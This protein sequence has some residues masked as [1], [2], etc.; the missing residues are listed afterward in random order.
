MGPEPIFVCTANTFEFLLFFMPPLW[1]R[2]GDYMNE[3]KILEAAVASVRKYT[4]EVPKIA[5]ILGSGL[6]DFADSIENAVSIDYADIEGFFTPKVPGHAG[7]LIIGDVCGIKV[8]ALAGRFHYYE[9]HDIAA[10]VRPVRV[11]R[12]LG[13]ERLILTNAAGGINTDYRVGDFM[14]ISDH[15][16]ALIPSP[17]RGENLEELG[18]RFPDMTSVYSQ[19]LRAAAKKCALDNGITVHEGVY[20]QAP[21]PQFET[22]AEIKMYRSWGA[23]AVGMSTACEAI[24][25]RH[26]GYEICGISMISNA[27]AGMSGQ[28]LTHEEVKA[29]A[30]LASKNFAALVRSVVLA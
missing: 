20:I 14:L 7:R 19:N 21:G 18:T 15:I 9:G 25:A 8:A 2:I 4:D 6:G 1:R 3:M 23:D 24:A 16:G 12:M 22:P 30:N 17:L 11:L 5:I 28:P 10:V 27:A 29:A 13:A 26:C